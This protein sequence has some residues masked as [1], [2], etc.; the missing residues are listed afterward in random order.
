MPLMTNDPAS[1]RAPS[2][3]WNHGV[4]A[5]TSNCRPAASDKAADQPAVENW[6]GAKVSL[7]CFRTGKPLP[8][9]AHTGPLSAFWCR[10][11]ASVK[12]SLPKTA[13]EYA[14]ISTVGHE[15]RDAK[16]AANFISLALKARNQT[17]LG[18][19]QDVPWFE[20]RACWHGRPASSFASTRKRRLEPAPFSRL[21]IKF[22]IC[23]TIDSPWALIVLVLVLISSKAISN[24]FGPPSAFPLRQRLFFT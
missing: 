8:P 7:I 10:T 23:L 22:W 18:H 20:S 9:G 1:I 17:S 16:G 24:L 11:A 13:Q 12:A 19:L 3:H 2:W 14:K 5:G 21:A 15:A 4:T 6:Q